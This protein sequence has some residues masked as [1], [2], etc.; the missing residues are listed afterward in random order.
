M[1]ELTLV[2]KR[3]VNAYAVLVLANRNPVIPTEL[4]EYVNI[5]VAEI[6]IEKLS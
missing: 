1:S 5:R 6:E 4:Q 3:L 2:Q